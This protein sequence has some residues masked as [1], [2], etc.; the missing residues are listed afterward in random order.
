MGNFLV[1][2]RSLGGRPFYVQSFILFTFGPQ[3]EP[4][5][6]ALL[7]AGQKQATGPKFGPGN[8]CD[9]GVEI[10]DIEFL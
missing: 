6:L 5:R 2:F 1:T 8:K 7:D 10:V 9:E 4:D 3:I